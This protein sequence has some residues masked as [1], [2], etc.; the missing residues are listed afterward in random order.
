MIKKLQLKLIV[1]VMSALLIV[2]TVLILG[3]NIINYH[4]IVK[5]AEDSLALFSSTG[6]MLLAEREESEKPPFPKASPKPPDDVPYFSVIL[7]EQT[8]DLLHANISPV[9]TPDMSKVT[10]YA[11]EALTREK[12]RGFISTYRYCRSVEKDSVHITFIDCRRELESFQEFL[13]TSIAVSFT[14]YLVI[15]AIIVFFSNRLVRPFSENYEKQ[16]RFITDAG[17]EIKTPLTII[18]A[19]VDILIMDFGENEWLEDIQKQAK[20]LT[21]LTNDL[22][23]LARM[24]E[25]PDAKQMI[26]FPFSDVVSEAAVSFQAL[27]QT[28][29]KTF[30]CHITPMLSLKGDEKAI[31]QLV[32]ILLDNALKYSPAKAV[33]S[34]SLEKQNKIFLLSVTN[35]I[36]DSIPKECLPLL[37][38][39][40]YRIDSSRSSQTGG[41]GIGLSL[42]KAIVT[43]HNGK[44][45]A[46]AEDEHS[47]SILVS[48]PV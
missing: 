25:T 45:Y 17:H 12:S 18:N 19:D 33:I 47:L 39:R 42:A 36:Q 20:R 9:F 2:L 28:Q 38:E 40:F 29:E 48:L 7:N 26:E 16:K 37:F 46:K 8:G 15:F 27:A 14:S 32:S 35:T 5:K 44:I 34:L 21:A 10:D 23:Y 41:Y 11:S 1:L 24:E 4:D 30:A 13:F 3:I 43:A 6:S 22:I 31:R